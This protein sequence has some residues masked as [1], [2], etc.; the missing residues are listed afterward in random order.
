[1]VPA[2]VKWDPIVPKKYGT[3]LED[4]FLILSHFK[5]L[6]SLNLYKGDVKRCEYFVQNLKFNKDKERRREHSVF[7]FGGIS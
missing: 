2:T 6:L 7:V 3:F 5:K 4:C 1:M